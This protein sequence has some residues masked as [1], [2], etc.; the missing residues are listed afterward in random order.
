[1]RVALPRML[2]IG[3]RSNRCSTN[4]NTYGDRLCE[5]YNS[6]R[7]DLR[8]RLACRHVSRVAKTTRKND[9]PVAGRSR[10]LD[11]GGRRAGDQN[12]ADDDA[13]DLG[14]III[15]ANG[16]HF[17]L[18]KAFVPYLMLFFGRY[19]PA[20]LLPVDGCSVH[21]GK[22]NSG[23]GRRALH[24]SEARAPAPRLRGTRRRQLG[25]RAGRL[26][27]TYPVVPL[28]SA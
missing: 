13:A 5:Q 23:K 7:R 27:Q 3:D 19:L 20:R 10:E 28:G 18:L 22:C 1:L 21:V 24:P 16:R 6:A 14:R 25:P 8:R 15:T 26:S 9:S 2:R 17:R 11:R 4:C 12:A